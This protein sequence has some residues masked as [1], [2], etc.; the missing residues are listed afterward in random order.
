[1]SE[2]RLRIAIDANVLSAHWGGIPKYLARIGEELLAGGDQI[3]LLANR[4]S[5][6][7]TIAGANEVGV[8]VKGTEIWRNAFVPLWSLRARPDVLWAPE[9]VL[10]RWSPVPTVTTVHDLAS[11]R[12]P[13]IKPPE[14][15]KRFETAVARSVRG[16]TRTIAVSQTTAGDVERFYA[17]G[18][19][20]VRVVPNGVDDTF[21]PG[22]RDAALAAVR[23][24]W[25]ITEPFVL[26][27]G[28]LEPRK[29][30]EVLIEA[31]NLAAAAG[32]GWRV[33]LAG[34]PG[35]QAEQIEAAARAS[36][37]CELIGEVS[38]GELLDLQRAAGAFA[39]PALF[40]GFGIA[41]LE[42]MACGTPA[43]IA[44]DSGGLEEV[45]GPAAIVVAERS[46]EAW[47]AALEE[48]LQRPPALIERGL[49]HAA[50]FRWPA[51]AA[52]TRAVLAEAAETRRR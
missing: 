31:A 3:D 24:R 44:A 16:A 7:R 35:F 42:A 26:H 28:S 23:E 52:Q 25:G 48:A 37:A 51:V 50:K 5:F 14:H 13:G 22:D 40:E 38:E 27:V 21:T 43:V 30:V 8:R 49:A 12:F 10:P 45:S 9:S 11:L 32:G 41:P 29:G 36:S 34:N 18:A 4:N 46:A 1:M 6:G 2:E 15:V 17:V 39:A 19:D 33:V 20:R 47:K